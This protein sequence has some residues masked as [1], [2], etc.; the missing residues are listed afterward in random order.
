MGGEGGRKGCG[1][2]KIACIYTGDGP[3][4]SAIYISDVQKAVFG[5][6]RPIV[7]CEGGQFL[8]KDVPNSEGK[9]LTLL[10]QHWIVSPHLQD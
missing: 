9:S 2:G 8:C 1:R 4:C 3:L 7:D 10:E 5:R 6:V